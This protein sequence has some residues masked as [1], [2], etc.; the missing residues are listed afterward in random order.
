[1]FQDT[2]GRTYLFVQGNN[3]KGRTWFL[4]CYEIGWEN[5]LPVVRW[6]SSQFPMKR[7]GPAAHSEGRL[8]FS[9]GWTCWRGTGPRGGGLHYSRQPGASVTIDF[10]GTSVALI[11]KAG[12]DCGI[13][14]V[15]IDG[16]VGRSFEL[17]TYS[18]TV[19]WNR[20]TTVA[21]DLSA[22]PHTIAVEVTGKK[23]PKSND[24]YIQ[25]VDLES[26]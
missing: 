10:D 1:V 17:D 2:G 4:S 13:G 6:D 24:T 21:D 11:Y 7:P 26:R 22:G 8:G 5:G 19:E 3:D 12:P 18:A 20:R 25:I 15:L 23:N 16:Q 9:A 14:R